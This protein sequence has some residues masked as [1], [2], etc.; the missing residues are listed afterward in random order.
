MVKNVWI[1]GLSFSSLWPRRWFLYSLGG[2]D[3]IMGSA[4]S[5]FAVSKWRNK[6]QLHGH[7][8]YRPS[9]LSKRN[10]VC[11]VH[12][13]VVVSHR[14]HGFVEVRPEVAPLKMLEVGCGWR[15]SPPILMKY[16]HN[17]ASWP[18]NS[19][20]LHPGNMVLHRQCGRAGALLQRGW[21][22]RDQS[23]TTSYE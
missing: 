8:K 20:L 19:W 14:H 5:C 11:I 16:A 22:L 2:L 18:G 21:L 1:A 4:A 9:R 6:W 15:V 10:T 12:Y 17:V 23:W 13:L 7:P 3:A